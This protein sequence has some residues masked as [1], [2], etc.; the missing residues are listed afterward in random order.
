[1]TR[2]NFIFVDLENVHPTDFDLLKGGPFKI[3]LFLG[4]NQTNIRVATVKALQPLGE[5]AEYIEVATA[6]KNALDFHI[7]WYMGMLAAAEPT[8]FFHVISGDTGFDPL[9]RHLKSRKIYAQRC[10]RIADIPYFAPK[11]DAALAAQVDAVLN[12]LIRRKASR[13]RTEKTLLSTIDALF[14]KELSEAQ[15]ARLWQTLRDRGLVKTEGN[16]LTY[17]LPSSPA[18]T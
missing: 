5:A 8:A 14:R 18:E 12:D 16:R 2:T 1:M 4:P 11:P 13:P 9:L 7:A 17:V 3:K 6:G 10:T 15:L